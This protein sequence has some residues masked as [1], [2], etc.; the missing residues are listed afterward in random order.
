[1]PFS[2]S[3]YGGQIQLNDRLLK[4]LKICPENIL[5]S[6]GVAW[7]SLPKWLLDP[8]SKH[9]HRKHQRAQNKNWVH[10]TH[11]HNIYRYIYIENIEPANLDAILNQLYSLGEPLDHQTHWWRLVS[12]SCLMLEQERKTPH[13][14]TFLQRPHCLDQV[15]SI[16]PASELLPFNC[17]CR[18]G[19]TPMQAKWIKLDLLIVWARVKFA[20]FC[21]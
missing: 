3:Q 9:K 20:P 14:F 2:L 6:C 7:S 17:S 19:A 10:F 12:L 8:I 21:Y 18:G 5:T 15:G 13:L 4:L 16:L 11:H 1:M